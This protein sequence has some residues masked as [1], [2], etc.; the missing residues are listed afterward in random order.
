MIGY[1][2]I[3]RDFPEFWK[4]YIS[5]YKFPYIFFVGIFW[6]FGTQNNTARRKYRRAATVQISQS[7]G[8]GLGYFS[9]P[10]SRGSFPNPAGVLHPLGLSRFHVRPAFG[11]QLFEVCGIFGVFAQPF[12][13]GRIS[14]VEHLVNLRA[15]YPPMITILP[16][17]FIMRFCH[18]YGL[19]HL[20]EVVLVVVCHNTRNLAGLKVL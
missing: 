20:F 2:V 13:I 3:C 12:Q 16:S 8:S 10:C 4:P 5:P 11:F 1:S 7:S 6:N 17:R 19:F 15:P 14:D 9:N 18:L